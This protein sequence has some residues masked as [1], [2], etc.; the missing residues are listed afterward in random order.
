MLMINYFDSLDKHK[1]VVDHFY[2]KLNES[3]ELKID[4]EEYKTHI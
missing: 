1:Y 3:E 2:D 4:I